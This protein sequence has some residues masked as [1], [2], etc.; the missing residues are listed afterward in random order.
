[1]I[2]NIGGKYINPEHVTFLEHRAGDSS[3]LVHLVTGKTVEV[4]GG[5]TETQIAI[6]DAC[7]SVRESRPT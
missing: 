6:N 4:R 2:V 5:K 1:M 7:I 3:T